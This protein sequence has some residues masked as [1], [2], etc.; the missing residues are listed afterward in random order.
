M[1][2]EKKM[3]DIAEKLHEFTGIMASNRARYSVIMGGNKH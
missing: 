1:D 2:R 3:L